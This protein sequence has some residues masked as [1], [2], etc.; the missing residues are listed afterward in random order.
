M[1]TKS[2]QKNVA[3]QVTSSHR[4]Q[5]LVRPLVW[6]AH[7]AKNN[8]WYGV[9][10]TGHEVCYVYQPWDNRIK[11]GPMPWQVFSKF[12]G[13]DHPLKGSARY[14]R[15]PSAGH[16]KRAAQ[17][18]WKAKMVAMLLPNEKSPDA[19]EKGNADE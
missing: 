9:T 13:L 6:Q 16:A 17:K 2:K 19:G 14:D 5:R 3:E 11:R 10:A 7:H 4:E 18:W 12:G 1:E 8:G 15:F